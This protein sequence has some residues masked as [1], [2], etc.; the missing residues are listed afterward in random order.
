MTDDPKHFVRTRDLTAEDGIQ[1]KHPMTGDAE[2]HWTT[3]SDRVGLTRAHLNLAR[4][5]PGKAAF[6]LHSHAVQEEFVFVLSGK[7][8]AR[9]GNREFPVGPGDYLG[10]PT[11]GVAHDIRNVGKEDLVCLMGGERTKTEVATFPELGKIAIQNQSG[12]QFYDIGSSED[13]PFSDW[14]RDD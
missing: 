11:D 4:I 3:L 12:M 8:R 13:R 7:G 10:F 2:V 5:P 9:V 6:P 14:T 1:V